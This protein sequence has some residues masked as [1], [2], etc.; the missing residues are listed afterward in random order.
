MKSMTGFAALEA[1]D[2]GPARSWDIRTV[3]ARGLDIR[4]R[5]ADG[6]EVLEKMARTKI[7]KA[8]GRG[9]VSLTLKLTRMSDAAALQ[10]NE[11]ALMAALSALS[12]VEVRAM[13][14]GLSLAPCNAADVLSVRGVLEVEP[15][16]GLPVADAVLADDLDRLLSALNDM[17]AAE[18]AELHAVLAA[19]IFEIEALT[20]VATD[21]VAAREDHIKSV[22]LAALQRLQAA[23]AD[24]EKARHDIAAL[25]V[26]AD[27]TEEL[28]RLRA[29]VVSA[30]KLLDQ[31][32]PIGRKLDF[33]TQ[34]FNREAN[35]LCSKAQFSELTQIGLSL[36]S[37][38]DQMR[39]QV[40][41]V[42]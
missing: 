39:E 32:G 29:H 40:Q 34:E 41:N 20:Q 28:D 36:K 12:E 13:S 24:P 6:S 42:E 2:G 37:V 38:I 18:G 1:N 3:N 27:V 17:R 5:L 16:T 26:K 22:F 4:V 19:Q 7:S 14:Q 35:T 30:R 21:L 33:L 11:P 10:V 15:V 8:V 23:D 31:D 9:N 25:A